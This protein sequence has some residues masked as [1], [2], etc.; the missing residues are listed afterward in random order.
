MDV[1]DLT[2]RGSHILVSLNNRAM[3]IRDSHGVPK[4]KLCSFELLRRLAQKDLVGLAE[5]KAFRD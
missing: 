5:D 1:E 3:L 4:V 2:L